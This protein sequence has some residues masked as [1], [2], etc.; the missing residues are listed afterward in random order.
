ME[1]QTIRQYATAHNVTYEAVRRQVALYAKE[2]EGHI[3][4]QNGTKYLDEE[5]QAFLTERRRKSVI[6][7]R[8]EDQTEE[9]EKLRAETEKLRAQLA[10]A[11][12]E[13]LQAQKQV[14]DLLAQQTP[15]IEAKTR[16]ELQTE[17]LEEV[18]AELQDVKQELEQAK[19]EAN[20]FQ[21]TW[22]G[23]YYRKKG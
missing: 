13:L 22:F 8:A 19:D 23:L 10:A 15:L 18:K 11:Q 21:R 6:V 1:L 20:S 2:L 4:I 7:V 9:L 12:T 17:Q 16:Y 3:I 5:A 14:I